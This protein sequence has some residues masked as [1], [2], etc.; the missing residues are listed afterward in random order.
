MAG[1][2]LRTARL[3]SGV[4]SISQLPSGVYF[5]KVVT[6]ANNELTVKVLLR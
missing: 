3:S 1:N 4:A 2:T 5:V 6:T